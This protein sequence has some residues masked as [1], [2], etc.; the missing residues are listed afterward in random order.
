MNYMQLEDPTFHT[1]RG[2]CTE[3]ITSLLCYAP[4]DELQNHL[5]QIVNI[6]TKSFTNPALLDDYAFYFFSSLSYQYGDQLKE[7]YNNI[8][9]YAIQY[10]RDGSGISFQCSI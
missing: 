10:L 1:L 2:R 6:V 5:P 9:N 8:L 4:T 3:V 7:T